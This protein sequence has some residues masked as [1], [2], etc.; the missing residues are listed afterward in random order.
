MTAETRRRYDARR[1]SD[2]IAAAASNGNDAAYASRRNIY[3]S[4]SAEAMVEGNAET[5]K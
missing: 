3:L 1:V 4:D 5:L 2:I